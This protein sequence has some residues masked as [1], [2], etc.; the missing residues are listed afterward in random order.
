MVPVTRTFPLWGYRRLLKKSACSRNY[1]KRCIEMSGIRK[2]RSCC[3][4]RLLTQLTRTPDVTARW[5]LTTTY[6]ST[7]SLFAFEAPVRM[8]NMPF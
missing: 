7:S 1:A 5:P 6:L 2:L 4:R 8:F 3:A